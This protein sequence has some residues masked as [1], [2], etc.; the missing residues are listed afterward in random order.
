MYVV[1]PSMTSAQI[2]LTGRSSYTRDYPENLHTAQN[3]VY[4]DAQN[5]AGGAK[6]PTE[7]GSPVV[8]HAKM[9]AVADKYDVQGG[10]KEFCKS[11]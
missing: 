11:N 10:M 1:V 6:D 5:V 4:H 8:L 2:Q 7:P 9:Y 3:C